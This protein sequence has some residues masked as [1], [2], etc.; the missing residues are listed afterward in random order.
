MTYRLD[1]EG[2]LGLKFAY[3]RGRKEET[4]AAFDLYKVTLAAKLCTD[5]FSK[6]SC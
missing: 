2:H 6:A 5:V 3:N 1:E 4:G